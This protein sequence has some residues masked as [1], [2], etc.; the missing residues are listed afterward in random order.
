[1][2]LHSVRL[3]DELRWS[4]LNTKHTEL[5]AKYYQLHS[6]YLLVLNEVNKPII[7]K[8]AR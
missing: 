1:M 5:E 8:I 6:K 2:E 7:G 3:E 4:D